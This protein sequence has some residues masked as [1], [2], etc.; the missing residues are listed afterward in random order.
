MCASIISLLALST[1]SCLLEDLT[2]KG[3]HQLKFIIED[4]DIG[5]TR[6]HN[7]IFSK[8]KYLEVSWCKQLEYLFPANAFR[9]PIHLQSLKINCAPMLKYVF[10]RSENEDNLT[11]QYQ[12]NQTRVEFPVLKTLSIRDVPKLV[13]IYSKNYYLVAPFLRSLKWAAF[14]EYTLRS[15]NGL[16]ICWHT[17]QEETEVYDYA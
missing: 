1:E 3:C 13:S 17:K 5:G 11:Q 2:V 16:L 7:S 8:L 4:Q 6:M 12:D 15:S 14:P 9:S 10:G